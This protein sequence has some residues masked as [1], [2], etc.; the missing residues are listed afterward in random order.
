MNNLMIFK[1]YK[2]H[3]FRGYV[4][5][6]Y[7]VEYDRGILIIDGASR[8]DARPLAE[9]ITGKMNCPIDRLKLIAVTHCHPDHAGAIG[10]LRRMYNIPV[11]APADIDNWYSGIGGSLQHISDTLQSKYMA[12]KMKSGFRILSYDRK[13]KPEYGLRD[14]DA[15][16]FFP[17]W[18]AISAPGHTSHNIFL[19]NETHEIL[20]IAD[21]IIDSKGK[22]LPPVPVLFRE[23]MI[24]T[25]LKIK[26][27]KPKILMLAH[28]AIPFYNYD[29][30]MI[31]DT[32]RKIET[33]APAYIRMFYFISKF[34]GEYHR[35]HRTQKQT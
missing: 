17:D 32:I 14:G 12:R 21:T 18:K 1:E 33:G 30:K 4:Q 19:Y 27:I 25:L 23:Q 5:N 13:I 3:H 6:N 29:E 7:L 20:Y 11:A 35:I 9:F 16:P 34:T 22:Y 10:Y 8:P 15:L 24:E 28:G 26:T 2:I 31:D